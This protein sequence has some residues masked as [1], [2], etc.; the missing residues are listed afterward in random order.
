M[1]K[2]QDSIKATVKRIKSQIQKGMNP[3]KAARHGYEKACD[4]PDILNKRIL[5]QQRA[6]PCQSKALTHILQ[7]KLYTMGNS[8][9]I[10]RETEMTH[11]QP[12]LEDS[13][14]QELMSSPLLAH[15]FVLV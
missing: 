4:Y 13:R 3:E 15:S 7:R 1:E 2:C 12:H 5:I 6:L 14:H 8:I 9:P 11:L 10:R